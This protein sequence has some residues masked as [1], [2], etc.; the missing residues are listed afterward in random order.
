MKEYLHH[1]HN[2]NSVSSYI[3]IECSQPTAAHG[4]N[5]FL[6]PQVVQVQVARVSQK[7]EEE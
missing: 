5:M 1:I 2:N 4:K 3:N 7:E 6:H